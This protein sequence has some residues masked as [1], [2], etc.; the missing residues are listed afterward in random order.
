MMAL[1]KSFFPLTAY[2]QKDEEF[3]SFWQI[4]YDE[5]LETKRLL[6]KLSGLPN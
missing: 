2:M 4:I 1:C 6:L 5:Y 3:G